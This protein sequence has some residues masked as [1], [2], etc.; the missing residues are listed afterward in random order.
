MPNEL[1]NLSSSLTSLSNIQI[2][3]T[4]EE[5][6]RLVET[7]PDKAGQE[8]IRMSKEGNIT[9]VKLLLDAGVNVDA[10]NKVGRTALMMAIANAHTQIVELL[11]KAY[12]DVDIE[13]N[14]SIT[15]LML[16]A[17]EG[18]QDEVKLL[19]KNHAKVN[20]ENNKKQTALTYAAHFRF[21]EIVK[22]LIKYEAN[23]NAK[24]VYGDTALTDA[25]D[26]N[27]EEMVKMLV[28][29][30]AD[31]D[32]EGP[33]HDS[34]L[35]IAASKGNINIVQ[36]LL[37]APLINV[38]WYNPSN[39]YSALIN[40][41][42]YGHKKIIEMLLKRGANVNILSGGGSALM[43]AAKKGH[44]DVVELLLSHGADPSIEHFNNTAA[45]LAEKEGY[46]EIAEILNKAVKANQ[47]LIL[48]VKSNDFKKV[49]ALINDK[50]N[51]NKEDSEGYTPLM[52]AAIYGYKDIVKLLLYAKADPNLKTKRG[53]T[54]LTAL[55][56]A[57]YQSHGRLLQEKVHEEIVNLLLEANA[58]PNIS[59]SSKNTPLLLAIELP[60]VDM[61]E[62]FLKYGANPSMPNSKG[63]TPLML[64]AKYNKPYITRLLLENGAY[65]YINDKDNDGDTALMI[66]Q[67]AGYEKIVEILELG[68][69]MLKSANWAF[70]E[71][72]RK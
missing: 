52:Y 28:D 20:A 23:I 19:L 34:P 42:L 68:K 65:I 12:A 37:R 48:A 69:E 72:L 29:Y 33:S 21:W 46:K 44:K 35:M 5:A 13:D 56:D 36:I 62:S 9:A 6:K 32:I 47:E 31:V 41:A 53:H 40:A 55:F 30:G 70:K 49:Q 39:G 54:T 16:A 7:D 60:N 38:N 14:N 59:D 66:A 25:I 45:S 11:L 27:N 18:N 57:I 51:V 50:A 15:A 3:P 4:P 67:K 17:E 63:Q 1:V 61:V 64:A 24:T 58:D 8:L 22:L 2:Q 71:R 26:Q 10:Q 43:V